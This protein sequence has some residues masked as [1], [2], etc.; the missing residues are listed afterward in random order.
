MP[1]FTPKAQERL[2]KN[3]NGQSKR[4]CACIAAACAQDP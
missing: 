2:L 1:G 3:H 4:R